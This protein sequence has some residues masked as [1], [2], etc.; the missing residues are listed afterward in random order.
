[1]LA[2]AEGLGWR[3]EIKSLRYRKLLAS[4]YSFVGGCGLLGIEAEGAAELVAPWPDLLIS[5]GMR[6]EPLCRW[7]RKQSD[8]KTRVVFI[9]RPWAAAEAFDLV[10]TTPQYRLAEHNAVL[11]NK[12]TLHRV[13][14]TRLQQ[15]A[16]LFLP[17]LSALP[18]PLFAVIVG[19]D[20]GPFCF[21]PIAARR[22]ARQAS[23]LAELVNGA[24]LV[25]SSARTNPLA[26]QV[27]EAEISVPA[28]FYRWQAGDEANPYFAYLA[29]ADEIIVTAD[30]ISMLS[31]SCAMGKP[32]HLFDL[33][34]MGAADTSARDKSFRAWAYGCL[35]RCGP[36]R[37][38]RDITLVHRALLE[39]GQ[40]SWLGSAPAG[41][42]KSN[43][44]TDLKRAIERVQALFV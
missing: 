18:R 39:S 33:G 2:L 4:L 20:S 8:G 26:L 38:G 3:C 29:L 41:Q 27:L 24:L 32:V 34:G 16:A 43:Q 23:E 1:M 15:Q 37:L 31:E 13:T 36:K 21:G 6:N 40:A 28:D 19:G 10:V 30:S 42:K 12:L 35:M 11:Q 7:I 14:E 44:Q 17:K 9:G 22:L 5:A 25:T